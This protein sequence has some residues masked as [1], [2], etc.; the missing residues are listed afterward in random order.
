MRWKSM[1]KTV[2]GVL[3][4]LVT[5]TALWSQTPQV[6]AVRAG[7]L[8]D[9]KSGQE[10]TRQVVLDPGRANHRGRTRGSN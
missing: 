10:M 8:F 2:V 4:M 9:S 6:V 5:A 3:G 1:L 7:R